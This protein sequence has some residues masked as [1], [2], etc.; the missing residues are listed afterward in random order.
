MGTDQSRPALCGMEIA[1][2]DGTLTLAATD[3]WRLATWRADL[4]PG[5]PPDGTIVL[6]ADAARWLAK[7]RNWAWQA[8]PTGLWAA[9]TGWVLSA[10]HVLGYPDYRKFVLEAGNGVSQATLPAGA[11]Q[12]AVKQL[13]VG[14]KPR[15]LAVRWRDG[16]LLLTGRGFAKGQ[17][18]MPSAAVNLPA[19]TEGY[20]GDDA[21]ITLDPDLLHG[22]LQGLDKRMPLHLHWVSANR[23]L[24]LGAG[25]WVL[26]I[27][28][29][30]ADR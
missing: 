9:G 18:P 19:A 11:L 22:M 16:Q 23:P 30:R 13:R 4:A 29:C 2:A 5:G 21:T 3:G 10:E 8:T 28:A 17:Q 20:T 27:M 1:V 12:A 14:D 26:I 6:P 7:Q 25:G 24:S 15:R